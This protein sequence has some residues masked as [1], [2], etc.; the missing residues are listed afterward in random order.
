MSLPQATPTI[1]NEEFLKFRDFFYRKTGIFFE[2]TKHYFVDKRLVE[3][4]QAT[5]N[6]NFRSYFVMLRFETSGTELQALINLMTVNET[7]FFREEYQFTC[8][9]NSILEE[10]VQ[11]KPRNES[12]RIWSVPSSSG[13]EPYSLAIYLLE[14]WPRADDYNIELVASDIDTGILER[15]R[16]GRYDQRS[17]QHLPE[18]LLRKYFTK[19]NGQYQINADLRNSVEFTLV[20]ITDLAQMRGYRDFDVVFCRNLLIYFDDTSRRIAAESLFNAL[21]PG[22]FICLGHSESMSR[23]TPLFKVRKFPEAIVY[24][25]PR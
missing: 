21:R 2:E 6:D 13:E 20:N 7:Y 9:V 12:I 23:I 1:S 22:G 3:R 8:L 25:K 19:L 11:H 24:Q 5:G 15:A 17:I 18:P 14:H 4:I 10:V 16:Q